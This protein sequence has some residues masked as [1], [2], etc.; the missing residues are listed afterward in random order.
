MPSMDE[1]EL[2]DTGPVS[3]VPEKGYTDAEEELQI[4][5]DAEDAPKPVFTIRPEDEELP[6][7][8]PLFESD[9]EAKTF[10]KK[11]VQDCYDEFIQSWEKNDSY[12][13][14]VAESW[15][16]LYCDLPPKTKPFEHCANT[17]IPLALQNVIRYTNKIYTE[18][19][20]D[21]SN[22]FNFVPT[23]PQAELIAPIVSEHSNWQLRSR[24][25]GFKRQQHRGL[26]IFAVAGDV[27]CHSYYD[28]VTRRNCHEILTCDDF[29]TPYTHVSVSPDFS[30]VPWVARRIPFFKTK[31]KAM[32]DVWS[33]VDQVIKHEAP[34][35]GDGLAET[36]L[37]NTISDHLGEE[38][39]GQIRGEY[40]IIH[41]EGWLKLLGQDKERYCQLIFDLT[42]KT[43]LKLSIHETA[44]YAERYRYQYQMN[45]FQQYQQQQQ[46]FMQAQQQLQMMQMQQHGQAQQAFQAAAEIPVERPDLATQ[47]AEQGHAVLNQ[48][49]PEPPPPP[50]KP[51][52]MIQD[53][54]TPIPPRKE[55]IHMFS[56]GVC[57]EPM[58]GN[59]GIGIG[60][61]DAQLNLATNTV[62]S[63]FL[64][65]AT[66]GNG[67]TFITAS[68]V[69]FRSPFKIGPGVFNKAK[70]VMPSDLQNA[71]YELDFGQANPQLIQAADKLMQFGEQA[72]STPDLMSGAAGK[73]GE[74]ARGIQAR[75]EQINAM[76]AV[77]TQ[78]Y[79]DFVVQ[80]M[81]NNCKLNRTFM[82]DEEI[83]YVNRFDDNLEMNGSE[84]IKAAREMYDNEYEIELVS[85]LQFKSRSQKVSEA[86]E[87]VQLP[88]A[89]PQ[90]QANM[91]FLYKAISESLKARGMHRMAKT[92]LGPPPPLPQNTFGLPPGTPGSAIS[93]DNAANLPPEQ[94]QALQ[95]MQMAQQQQ[96][97]QQQQNGKTQEQSSGGPPG[98]SNQA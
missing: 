19:F 51:S 17:A 68:N 33:N 30:D 57:L 48:Q 62:W 65:A 76:I 84:M 43:A 13:K 85:D 47:A 88:N 72:S 83:F 34:E 24:I 32:S 80:I 2:L 55:P 36:E 31:L 79:A 40:E 8:I 50:P 97:A 81:K 52:W 70:N 11:L 14:K 98:Q 86:D 87:I 22:V 93:L 92:L 3:E 49:L 27:V 10:L 16:L 25:V 71:F 56:H 69:D 37:R 89:I 9:P 42:T 18:I 26:L 1:T 12:R 74:T 82:G 28:T 7:L 46:Q 60:R 23:N 45:E 73:S 96:A 4:N 91:A 21:W 61:I 94:V 78:K 5:P 67:K 39:Y 77:P 20:G 38:P 59:L 44:D 29:V 58:L 15:R 75:L 35:Y 63:Q 95:Q 53:G 41:Y 64:D 54:Q 66:L 90:L 6:N